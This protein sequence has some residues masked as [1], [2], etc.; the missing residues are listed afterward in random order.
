MKLHGQYS[1]VSPKSRPSSWKDAANLDPQALLEM[2]QHAR[3]RDGSLALKPPTPPA[4]APCPTT[5][6]GHRKSSSSTASSVWDSTPPAIAAP[7]LESTRRFEMRLLHHF[8]V[9]TSQSFPI[10]QQE[11][12][13]GRTVPELGVQYS[14]LLDSILAISA[15]HLS[16]KYP[17]DRDYSRASDRLFRGASEQYFVGIRDIRHDNFEAL[18]VTGLLTS[19]HA[20]ASM[21]EQ[22]EAPFPMRSVLSWYRNVHMSHQ[23][24]KQCHS[25]LQQS[26]RLR[27][28]ALQPDLHDDRPT[29]VASQHGPFAGIL[30]QQDDER[31]DPCDIEAYGQVLDYIGLMHRMASSGRAAPITVWTRL[32]FL[33]NH[34]PAR[35]ETFVQQCRPRAL[36]ALAHAFAVALMSPCDWWC[37]RGVSE[38]QIRRIHDFVGPAWTP[39]MAWPLEMTRNPRASASA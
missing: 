32:A 14:L 33:P 24:I 6:P 15:L 29:T 35:F 18:I 7:D 38:V 16:R 12:L 13:W 22:E 9:E 37:A 11:T 27:P 30:R 5:C 28:I 34:C 21:A 2:Q 4:V 3:P 23:V 8:T 1:P 19:T 36:V 10:Y 17:E 31:L 26:D 39:L 20:F 25:H